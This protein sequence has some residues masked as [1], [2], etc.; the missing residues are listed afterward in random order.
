MPSPEPDSAHMP[1]ESKSAHAPL[2][3]TSDACSGRRP[4][5]ALS[6]AGDARAAAADLI[7]QFDSQALAAPTAIVVFCSAAHD[8]AG[9][10]SAL[11]QRYPSAQVVGCTTA[12]EFVE[13]DGSTG[14]VSAIALP[15]GTARAA[16]AT[17]AR[18]DRD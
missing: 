6:R 16:H 10:A 9:L 17:L 2:N 8:G 18:F 7:A 14:G 1:I 4:A 5:S 15:A 11:R 12:G 3:P 13:R